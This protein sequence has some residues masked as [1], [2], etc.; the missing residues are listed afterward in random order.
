VP[1]DGLSLEGTDV[2]EDRFTLQAQALDARFRDLVEAAPDAMVIANEDGLIVLLNDQ[3]ARLF[4]CDR[5]DLVGSTVET[6]VPD[7]FRAVH[8]RHRAG[9]AAEPRTR[10]MGQGLDLWA[11]RRDGTEFPAEISL[12]PLRTEEGVFTI[13]AIRDATERKRLEEERRRSHELEEERRRFR[14]LVQSDIIGIIVADLGGP[15]LEA[16]DHFLHLVGRDR[17]DLAGGGLRWDALTPPEWHET[18]ARSLGSLRSAGVAP[19]WEKEFLR[20]D[21][22][23]VPVL[24]GIALLDEHRGICY[25]L[26]ISE[27]KRTERTLALY[28]EELARSN[29]EL[30]AFASVASHDLQEPL[31]TVASF[32]QLLAARY[33]ERLDAD[34]HELLDFVVGGVERMSALIEGLLAVSRVG[35]RSL[36]HGPVDCERVLRGVLDDLKA[37]LEAVGASVTRGPLPTLPGD[38]T[39]LAQLLRNLL[40]NAVKFRRPGVPPRVEISAVR[41][42]GDWL[43]RVSDNGLGIEPQYFERIFVIFQRLHL[44]DEYPGTGIGLAVCRRVVERHGGRIWVESDPSAGSTF[45]FTLPAVAGGS[46]RADREAGAP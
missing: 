34:G 22:A 10:P 4:D 24:V 17:H 45:S 12:S 11:R 1:P 28:A 8:P 16:N 21:G 13:A 9:Y 7:R 29:R 43:F 23:R 25:V 46:A 26:D 35:T 19:P 40:D 30:E 5:G 14:R 15:I 27:R 37:A 2:L 38:E 33:G 18:D 44:Q 41:E 42:G 39:Q 3:A 20:A 36:P 32:T 31:R 6:L